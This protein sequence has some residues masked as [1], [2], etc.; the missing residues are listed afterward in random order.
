MSRSLKRN[1]FVLQKY[2][3]A[4]ESGPVHPIQG[5]YDGRNTPLPAHWKTKHLPANK[6][7]VLF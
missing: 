7:E 6:K 5:K 2:F 1:L 4:V 3:E